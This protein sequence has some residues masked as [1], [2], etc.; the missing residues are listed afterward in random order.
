MKMALRTEFSA[1]GVM[2]VSIFTMK[3]VLGP[4]LLCL[5][6][7]ALQA[8]PV[9]AEMV[10]AV[11]PTLALRKVGKVSG[12]LIKQIPYGSTIKIVS[13][14]TDNLPFSS[15]ILGMRGLW[16]EAEYDGSRGWVFAP[17]LKELGAKYAFLIIAGRAIKDDPEAP[18]PALVAEILRTAATGSATITIEPPSDSGQGCS[19]EIILLAEG[20]VGAKSGVGC[21]DTTGQFSRKIEKWHFYGGVIY[22]QGHDKGN[23]TCHTEECEKGDTTI[24]RSAMAPIEISRKTEKGKFQGMLYY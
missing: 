15:D 20:K 24:N 12:K 3:R 11:K 1:F 8:D 16:Y 18:T 13:R 17:L 9:P 22:V 19:G 23:Y 10:V 14:N 21:G 2:A 6:T 4:A 7:I 5:V